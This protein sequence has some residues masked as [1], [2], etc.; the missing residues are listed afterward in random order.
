MNGDFVGR[1][2]SGV[3]TSAQNLGTNALPWGVGYMN[4]LVLDGS[5]V[6]TSLLTAPKN[7]I[8]SGKKRSASNQ[9]QFIDPNGAANSFV[10]EGAS[11][12]LVLDIDGST[13]QV[14][15]DI[16]KSSLTVGPSSS[17]TCLINDTTAADQE[18]TKIWGEDG[19][20]SE[21]DIIVDAM[22]AEFQAFIGQWVIIKIV[23][24]S[25]E[26]AM[27]FVKSAILLTN[28]YRG[29]FTDS[30]SAPINRTAFFNNDT[31]TV[32]STGW[33]FV[34]NNGT[35]VDVSYTNP[36]RSF[37]APT[38]PATGDYW[39]DLAN[40]TWKRY[41]GASWQII[42]R[43]LIGVVGIDSANCVCARSFDFFAKHE[44]TNTVEMEILSTSIVQIKN[45]NARISVYGNNINFGFNHENWNITTDLAGSADMYNAAE[46]AST[47][48]Y[49]YLKDTGETVISDISPHFRPDLLGLYHPHNPW[50]MVGRFSNSSGS[51]IDRL[52]DEVVINSAFHGYGTNGQGSSNT[53]INR[54]ATTLDYDGMDIEYTDSVSNGGLLEIRR[55]GKYVLGHTIR[56]DSAQN[57]GMSKNSSQLTTAI[58]S[59]TA[60]DIIFATVTASST[61]S[62]SYAG[63]YNF[64]PG[65]K[66][67]LHGS[68]AATHAAYSHTTLTRVG[69][70]A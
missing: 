4:S 44:D 10:L 30:S 20:F 32:M 64:L 58:Q 51:D 27:V 68:G 36:I 65:D 66:I 34:E 7:R 26:Y 5:A 17:A 62:A 48:Y 67:R 53:A 70:N 42:N 38:G 69:D 18:S 22:G 12:N 59:I 37:T 15:T 40:K 50:R 61:G 9:P 29:F 57:A 35:T 46:Q 14:T 2:S 19:G 39:Y 6:D 45:Q 11:T 31:I 8:V 24:V 3:A 49:A 60:S 1:N 13:V 56:Y 52:S 55:K 33:V 54:I 63:S 25:T 28:A 21:K 16:T 41:D 47:T 43:T 23:G